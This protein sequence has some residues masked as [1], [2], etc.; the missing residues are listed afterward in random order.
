MAFSVD[1]PRGYAAGVKRGV[2]F[3]GG[4]DDDFVNVKETFDKWNQKVQEEFQ[5][6]F[7]WWT[8][9]HL[10]TKRF[11]GWDRSEYRGRYTNCFVFKRTYR[12]LYG[13][14]CHPIAR[15]P[16]YQVVVLV[17]ACEKHQWETEERILRRVE[18]TRQSRAV[19]DV[20]NDH[21]EAVLLA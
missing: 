13:F 10:N 6:S 7:L 2:L 3:L 15:R 19:V 14:L 16:D 21:A 11:H 20:L 12:R 9:G 4:G 1:A 18:E 8:N 5:A 17:H